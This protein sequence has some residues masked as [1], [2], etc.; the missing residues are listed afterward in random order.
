MNIKSIHKEEN[1]LRA[2][3]Q[4][5]KLFEVNNIVKKIVPQMVKLMKENNGCGIA[6]TQVG[7]NKTFFVA[8]LGQKIRVFINPEII[9]YSEEKEKDYEGCLSVPNV[10]GL[11]ERHLKVTVKYFDGKL[12][13]Q[14]TEVF[15]GHKARIVQHEID[16]LKGILYTDIAEKIINSK[17][18][19]V[20]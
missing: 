13:R 4:P 8:E 17:E 14:N 2:K 19:Q 10:S 12:M 9:D 6:S 11:V 7:I 18:T 3:N 20:G 16:H 1:I 15:R 5:V